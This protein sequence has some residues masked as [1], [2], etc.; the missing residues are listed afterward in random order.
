MQKSIVDL[1]NA[2]FA[3]S[4]IDSY[5]DLSGC[6]RVTACCGFMPVSAMANIP[7]CA[8]T[9]LPISVCEGGYL[10]ISADSK[11][12]GVPVYILGSL[13]PLDVDADL[14]DYSLNGS[15]PVSSAT[16]LP[17]SVCSATLSVDIVE[18]N[19]NQGSLPITVTDVWPGVSFVMSAY[20]C[21]P[22]SVCGGGS[23]AISTSDIL[24]ISATDLD[25]DISDV[26]GISTSEC[27]PISVCGGGSLP[28]SIGDTLG[29]STTDT[30]PVSGGNISAHVVCGPNVA[31]VGDTGC[32]TTEGDYGYHTHEGNV[33][34][35]SVID[36]AVADG[37]GLT[38]LVCVK[39]DVIRGRWEAAGGGN[40]LL[41]I[42]ENPTL[43]TSGGSLTAYNKDRSSV[44]TSNVTCFSKPS[45]GSYGTLIQSKLL[46]EGTKQ[47]AGD[48]IGG[49][50]TEWIFSNNEEYLFVLVNSAGAT[51]D[52]YLGFK[53]IE[54]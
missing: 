6:M 17:V 31:I 40:A 43:T 47:F 2:V 15:L 34:V 20:D 28:V 7:I 3:N 25:V 42:Y 12:G 19:I 24:A 23:L 54:E 5:G 11:Y 36:A 10:G 37:S 48:G 29:I 8:S 22:I 52:L 44:N 51:K 14:T 30:F 49:A 4:G 32:L 45:V 41:Y 16:C 53:W 9:C 50:D 26:I 35:V 21:L 1:W 27:L 33:Y 13:A 46:P 39:D 18:L 38:L